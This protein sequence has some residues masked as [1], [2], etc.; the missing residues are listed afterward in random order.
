MDSNKTPTDAE[1][2]IVSPTTTTTQRKRKS[3]DLDTKFETIYSLLCSI[4]C[5][6]QKTKEDNE[7]NF[8][9]P[10]SSKDGTRVLTEYM[11]CTED[12]CG[13]ITGQK[14]VMSKHILL[15]HNV[16]VPDLE[17]AAFIKKA[18]MDTETY[19]RLLDYW[20]S[21]QIGGREKPTLKRIPRKFITK[22]QKDE[23]QQKQTTKLDPSI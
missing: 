3:S 1:H 5:E 17:S 4:H 15:Y 9:K 22:L 8:A 2:V 20:V 16:K 23:T 6:V 13:F 14:I 7:K 18:L 12:K 21:E 10:G 19:D 11:H